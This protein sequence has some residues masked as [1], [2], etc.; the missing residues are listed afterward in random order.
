MVGLYS[1]VNSYITK[2]IKVNKLSELIFNEDVSFVDVVK[3][4][5]ENFKQTPFKQFF[6]NVVG[7]IVANNNGNQGESG[8]ENG[9][10][11][12]E[13]APT[14]K[15]ID[16]FGLLKSYNLNFQVCTIR[17]ETRTDNVGRPTAFDLSLRLEFVIDAYDYETEEIVAQENEIDCD[18]SIKI[19][20]VKPA[21][22]FEI[23]QEILDK[24]VASGGEVEEI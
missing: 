9:E 2:I 12:E 11:G 13:N 24:A 18:V 4:L 10:I 5:V 21:I 19:S 7:F 8:V 1:S 14:V 6:N 3:N 23:P 17:G 22:R 16:Y 15:Y 20:Y